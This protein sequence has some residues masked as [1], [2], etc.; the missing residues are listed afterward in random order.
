V[1]AR[2]AAERGDLAPRQATKRRQQG[3]AHRDGE[4][5]LQRVARGH[6]PSLT[7]MAIHQVTIAETGS[8]HSALG[9]LGL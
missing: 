4:E 3:A 5:D 6:R 1:R 9:D 2:G 7:P 8:L